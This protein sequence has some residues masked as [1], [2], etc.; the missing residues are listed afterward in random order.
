MTYLGAKQESAGISAQ[1]L[2]AHRVYD[3]V[4]MKTGIALVL[5]AVASMFAASGC[6]AQP[7]EDEEAAAGSEDAV[8]KRT[9][10]DI[11]WDKYNAIYGTSFTKAEDAFSVAVKVG[12]KTIKAPSHLFGEAVNVIPYS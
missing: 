11:A 3:D 1:I 10:Y 12:D 9:D 7:V 2:M 5:A 8:T 6:S 4:C